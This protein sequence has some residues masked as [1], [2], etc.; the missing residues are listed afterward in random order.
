MPGLYDQVLRKHRAPALQNLGA[1]VESPQDASDLSGSIF[2]HVR[3]GDEIALDALIRQHAF[4]LSRKP[5]CSN[6]LPDHSPTDHT[7]QVDLGSPAV[8]VRFRGLGLRVWGLGFR[9]LGFR[10]L[11]V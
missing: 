10:G 11:A 7:N 2:L 8:T 9:G 1:D 5:G 3:R 6:V 4:N